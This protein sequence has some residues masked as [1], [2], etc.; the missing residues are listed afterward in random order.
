MVVPEANEIE[1]VPGIDGRRQKPLPGEV[2]EGFEQ[3]LDVAVLPG[4]E[5]GGALMTDAEQ[6]GGGRGAQGRSRRLQQPALQGR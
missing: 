3:A 2:L 4:R 5:G 1:I 6:A